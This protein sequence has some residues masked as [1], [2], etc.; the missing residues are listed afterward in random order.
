LLQEGER[1]VWAARVVSRIFAFD[2]T[3]KN[4]ISYLLSRAA[5]SEH[6]AGIED[7]TTYVNPNLGFDGVSYRASGWR[8]LG[9]E[10][11]TT[12]RYL[13]DLYITDRELARRY[14]NRTDEEFRQLLGVRFDV[15]RMPLKPLLV[16]HLPLANTGAGR[17]DS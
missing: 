17:K 13:D 1:S 9:I 15:S 14:G 3:P 6:A 2:G 10:P 4:S 5:E 7:L 8:L 12:Y 11:G 16:Y